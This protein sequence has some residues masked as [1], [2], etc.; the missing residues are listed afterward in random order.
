MSW[1]VS[2]KIKNTS[3]FPTEAFCQD[4]REDLSLKILN[5]LNRYPL[6]HKGMV[7]WSQN[8][9]SCCLA[10]RIKCL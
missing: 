9:I 10:L 1:F 2:E 6:N 7:W 4:S 5:C 8:L 3:T